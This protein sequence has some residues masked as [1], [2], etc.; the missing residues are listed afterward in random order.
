MPHATLGPPRAAFDGVATELAG[1]VTVVEALEQVALA[2]MSMLVGE[3]LEEEID[4]TPYDSKVLVDAKV[5]KLR[6]RCSL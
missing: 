1:S 5:Q 2:E 4:I 6:A 3:E